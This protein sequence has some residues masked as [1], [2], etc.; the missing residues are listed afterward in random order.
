MTGAGR[1]LSIED[2]LAARTEARSL[3]AGR[4]DRLGG[5]LPGLYR[6]FFKGRGLE[7]DE[8]RRY[9]SGDDRTHVDW[10]VTARTGQ[11]YTKAFREERE[12][13]VLFALDVSEGM[14][15]GTRRCQK[16]VRGAEL[17]ALIAWLAVDNDDLVGGLVYGLADGIEELGPGVG[18][19]AAMRLYRILDRAAD[20]PATERPDLARALRRLRR[21]AVHGALIVILSDFRTALSEDTYDLTDLARDKDVCLVHVHDPL[22]RHLP[23]GVPLMF[24]SERGTWTVAEDD[25][26]TRRRH[27][28]NFVDHR[29]RM[30]NLC[31]EIGARHMSLATETLP[32]PAL[33]EWSRHKGQSPT[34]VAG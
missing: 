14:R 17:M 30:E 19:T 26:I 13:T 6:S 33:L 21:H 11:L 31:R 34:E 1:R 27:A 23:E 2:W 15:F 7:Y 12:R 25:V 22:E 5:L 4:A 24:W 8:S 3:S 16:W 32:L 29:L 20:R 9:Q 28:S 10:R 18:E